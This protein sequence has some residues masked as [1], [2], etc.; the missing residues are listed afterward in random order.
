MKSIFSNRYTCFFLV[1]IHELVTIMHRIFE[2]GVNPAATIKTEHHL[3]ISIRYQLFCI[4]FR[5]GKHQSI[6]MKHRDEVV[7]YFAK[8]DPGLGDLVVKSTPKETADGSSTTNGSSY[9][10]RKI[11][12]PTDA[13]SKKKVKGTNG[14][15]TLSQREKRAME[16]LASY[17][18]DRGGMLPVSLVASLLPF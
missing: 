12:E 11:D 18:E 9:T 8:I 14:S 7:G 10:K 4:I 5:E 16:L 2:G 13:S 15:M 1:R 3:M 17:L 6:A